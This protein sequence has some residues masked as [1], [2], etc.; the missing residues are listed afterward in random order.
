MRSIGYL[1]KGRTQDRVKEFR[2]PEKGYRI[3]ETTD[4]L[5][6]KVT[7]HAVGDRQDVL[8]QPETVRFS[9]EELTR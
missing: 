4:E 2:H 1:A 7:Q 6:T 3:K 9:R 8:I 5:N